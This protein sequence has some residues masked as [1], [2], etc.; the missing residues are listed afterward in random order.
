MHASVTGLNSPK[1]LER[2]R[3]GHRCQTVLNHISREL[4]L[5]P[6]YLHRFIHCLLLFALIEVSFAP[7]S[8][9]EALPQKSE[10]FF[11]GLE[12]PPLAGIH[13][14]HRPFELASC[15]FRSGSEPYY[16]SSSHNG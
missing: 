16:K 14:F 3:A 5:P 15:G 12:L 7:Q 11:R 6:R 1:P 2:S 4:E 9:L 13:F 10:Q 8:F